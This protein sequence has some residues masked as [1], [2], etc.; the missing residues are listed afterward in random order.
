MKHPLYIFIKQYCVKL[1]GFMDKQNIFP[2]RD[3]KY[4]REKRAIRKLK[5]NKISLKTLKKKKN[6]R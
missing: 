2:L 3:L 6:S 4:S 1:L 5:C